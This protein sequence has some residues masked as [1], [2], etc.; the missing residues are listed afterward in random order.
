MTEPDETRTDEA[1]QDLEEAEATVDVAVEINGEKTDVVVPTSTVL[2]DLLRDEFGLHGV[3]TSCERTVCGACTV[4]VDGLPTASCSTFAFDVDGARVDT[5]E[6]LAEDGRLSPEQQAFAE[7]GG[8]QCGFC[9]SGMLMLTRAL[10][11]EH[12]RPDRDTIRAWIS[13]ST[14]RCTGYEM[15]FESVERAAELRAAQG[16]RE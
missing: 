7:C 9:T 1:V 16:S 8:F 2:S 11:D 14:C 6:G 15:I 10:L 13:S 4:L 5:V 12:P 3:R